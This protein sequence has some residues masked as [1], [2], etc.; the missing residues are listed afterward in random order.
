MPEDII[1]LLSIR[2]TP[3]HGGSFDK[4][5]ILSNMPLR[6]SLYN[7]MSVKQWYPLGQKFSQKRLFLYKG[8]LQGHKVIET[9]VIW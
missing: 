1:N 8:R 9:F 5:S 3:A 4:S 7:I 6:V 2:G